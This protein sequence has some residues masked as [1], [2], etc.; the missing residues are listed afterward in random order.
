[1]PAHAGI[2]VFQGGWIPAFAGMT[3]NQRFLGCKERNPVFIVYDRC[4]MNT[5]ST[6]LGWLLVLAQFVMFG[7]LVWPWTPP[8]LSVAGVLLAASG[9]LVGGWTLLHNRIGNFNVHP[10]PKS[11]GRLVTTGPYRH[12][13]HPMYT[14]VLLTMASAVFFYQAAIGKI[15]FWLGLLLVLWLKTRLE[16]HALR[17]RFP[18]YLDYARRAGCFLPRLRR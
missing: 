4:R 14:A 12:M 1:M 2:R 18:D 3:V 13:R 5:A 11:E 17:Q 8:V 15:G 6:Y 10:A 7:L 16:E 9:V